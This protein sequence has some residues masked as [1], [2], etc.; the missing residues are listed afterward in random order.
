MIT[1]FSRYDNK[2]K[3]NLRLLCSNSAKVML[4]L[5][6]SMLE[7]STSNST[8]REA[9]NDVAYKPTIMFIIF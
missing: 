7:V 5:C 1:R 9:R 4:R 8:T 2:N 3:K 6:E